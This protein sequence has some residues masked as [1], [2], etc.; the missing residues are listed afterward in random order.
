MWT[1]GPTQP[2]LEIDQ[3]AVSTIFAA[4]R[5]GP[6]RLE[7]L[8]IRKTV[9]AREAYVGK[10]IT[11]HDLLPVIPPAGWRAYIYRVND[12]IAGYVSFM[13]AN[14]IYEGNSQNHRIGALVEHIS[15]MPVFACAAL[16]GDLIGKAR[17]E[18][19]RPL[20][21]SVNAADE[22]IWSNFGFRVFG[23]PAD[24]GKLL[25]ID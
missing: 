14:I 6:R 15:M 17:Q 1:R 5:E 22:R 13:D 19:G 11:V 16:F 12:V 8:T 25:M 24:S 18:I 4:P 7:R 20:I 9:W 3:A 2:A 23:R 10:G 21:V